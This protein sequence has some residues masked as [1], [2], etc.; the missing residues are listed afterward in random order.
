MSGKQLLR[1]RMD[2]TN[3]YFDD[4]LIYSKTKEEH[5]IHLKEVLKLP[6]LGSVVN[7]YGIHVDEDKVRAIREWPTPKTASDVMKQ[8]QSCALIK[9]KLSTSPVLAISTFEKIIKVECDA[10]GVGIGTILPQEKRSV[11]FSLENLNE[12]RQKWSIYDY[13]FYVVVQALKQREPYLVQKSVNKMHVR[14][15]TFLHNIPFVIKHKYGVLNRVADALSHQATLL[16]ILVQEVVCL[17]FL[18]ELYE[19]DEDF[20][21]T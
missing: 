7:A 14:W 2:C 5:L 17:E 4:I 12:A 21:E 8:D 13:E 15:A 16:V 20:Q 19:T 9:E 18:K 11:A 10:S 3:V 1:P 6:F